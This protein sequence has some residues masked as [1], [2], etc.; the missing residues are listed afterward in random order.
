[1]RIVAGALGALLCMSLPAASAEP[2]PRLRG[3]TPF[4]AAIVQ[5]AVDQSPTVAAMAARIQRSDLIVFVEVVVGLDIPTGQTSLMGAVPH[6]RY[7]RVALNAHQSRRSMME[8][9]GHELQHVLEIAAA[10]EVRDQDGMRR[11]YERIA[12]PSRTLRFETL[13][14]KETGRLVAAELRRATR[15]SPGF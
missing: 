9:L 8:I 2:M 1:M 13:A 5:N 4:A 14:A 6:A 3:T 11:L 7:V 10:P 15:P 12:L